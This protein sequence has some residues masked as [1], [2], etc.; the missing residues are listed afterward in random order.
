M[1]ENRVKLV[2][3]CKYEDGTGTLAW[4]R[5]EETRIV[6][7]SHKDYETLSAQCELVN[8]TANEWLMH[9]L[10]YKKEKYLSELLER[11]GSGSPDIPEAQSW[12]EQFLFYIREEN[13]E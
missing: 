1:S 9:L 2:R 8:K 10:K 6:F 3:I 11:Y 13:H 12:L 5:D 4:F 7:K